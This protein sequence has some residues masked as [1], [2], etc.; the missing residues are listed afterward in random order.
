M[1]GSEALSRHV[2]LRKAILHHGIEEP[3]DQDSSNPE[4]C[5]LRGKI[6]K[7]LLQVPV[8]LDTE[9]YA[10]LVH[11]QFHPKWGEMIYNDIFRTFKTNQKF[12]QRVTQQKLTRVLN[13]FAYQLESQKVVGY[14]QGLN[15]I[16]GAFLYT[17][18]EIDSLFSLQTLVHSHI[19]QYIVPNLDGVRA[20]A[21]LV[22]ECLRCVD[23]EL[24][25]HLF[26]HQLNATIY[27]FPNLL[28]LNAC[29][30]PLTEVM[31]LWDFLFAFGVHM[32]ILICVCQCVNMRDELLA[33]SFPMQLLRTFP[34]L[35][36]K[37]LVALATALVHKIPEHLY[38]KI[39]RHTRDE[40]VV[41]EVLKLM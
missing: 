30:P 41:Y 8:N 5:G 3:E 38:D 18:P 25:T 13:A 16:A 7:I 40:E 19:P 22:D 20:A 39:C 34:S 32:N 11:H 24:H 15:V 6:W 26:A 28:T 17:M 12:H 9:Q 23:P 31:K 14:V 37:L 33:S 1:D 27:A 35:D 4:I 36:A 21:K 29:T 10:S 2:E